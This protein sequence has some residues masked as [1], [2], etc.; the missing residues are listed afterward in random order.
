MRGG[1]AAW[2]A[3]VLDG[4]ALAKTL[5]EELKQQVA[6]F[7]ERTGDHA[8]DRPGARR[9]GPGLCQLCGHDREGIHKARDGLCPAFLP[10]TATQE[11]IVAAVSE[12]NADSAVHGIMIQEPLPKGIDQAAVKAALSPTRTWMACIP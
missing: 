3:T 8:D 7:K 2:Q 1:D 4:R 10:E 11:E 6:A 9:R 12:L 5:R